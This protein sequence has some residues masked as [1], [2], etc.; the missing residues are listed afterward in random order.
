M[1]RFRKA[2]LSAA[3]LALS[4]MSSAQAAPNQLSGIGRDATPKEVAAW[5]IDVRADFKGLPPGSGSVAQGQ[6]IWESKCAQC[7]GFFGESGE[8]FNPIIGGVQPRDLQ[9]GHVANLITP[10]FPGRTTFMKVST[11]SS[12]WDFINRAMPWNAPKTL[13]TD[14]VYATLAFMLNIA[15]IVPEN[16]VLNEKTIRDVQARM[17]NRNGMTTEHALWP[18]NEFGS[19]AKPDT[20]NVACMKDCTPEPKVASFL[21]E[22]ARN[23]HGNLAEQNRMVGAQHG[24]DTT[25]PEPKVG[26]MP[27][28]VT[29]PVAAPEKV[30]VATD[31]GKPDA[32]KATA[33]LQKNGCLVCHG[34]S[35]KIVGPAYTDVAKKYPDKAD[36]LAGKIKSGGTGVW[37]PI[38]MPP[39]TLGAADAKTIAVWLAAGMPK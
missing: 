6:D 14:E 28:K 37:G 21:P 17:P 36:Y 26:D 4:V 25:K 19:K 18:G 24:A 27:T 2:V 11:I 5:D 20:A 12:V 29:A 23:A 7:H 8:V 10:G 33:L 22:F 32:K 31:T 30:A 3:L 1:F 34:M 15:G 13:K 38:P 9:T 16:F 39:Q 35:N